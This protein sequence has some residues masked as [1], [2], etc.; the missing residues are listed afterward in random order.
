MEVA[1]GSATAADVAAAVTAA[2]SAAATA[3]DSTATAAVQQRCG[4]N[5]KSQ[6]EREGQA[7][8]R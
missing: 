2:D 4:R 1:T 8:G 3:A 5:R 6:Q 7:Q